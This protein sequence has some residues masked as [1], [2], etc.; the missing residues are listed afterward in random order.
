MNLRKV[1]S[2]QTV[3]VGLEGRTKPEIVEEL[4]DLICTTGKVRDREQALA[5]LVAREQK[6]S[7]GMEHGVA[8]PHAKTDV[9]EELLA[10][11]ATHPSGVDF[12][13]LD[14]GLSRLFIVTL[15]PKNRTGPHIQFLAEISRI[16]RS[17]TVRERVLS[18]PTPEDIIRIVTAEA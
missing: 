1:L 11:V 13:S 4:L 18:A 8:I 17:E 14:G 10:A 16:L 7:T 5:D 12:K 2:P 3:K 6:M 15:S 9:V